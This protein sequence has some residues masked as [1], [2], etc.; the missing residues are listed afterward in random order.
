[1]SLVRAV[2]VL[3]QTQTRI[4]TRTTDSNRFPIQIWQY[5]TKTCPKPFTSTC[6]IVDDVISVFPNRFVLRSRTA[7]DD[8]FICST[9]FGLEIEIPNPGCDQTKFRYI[10]RIVKTKGVVCNIRF[11]AGIRYGS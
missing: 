7:K 2:T 8:I 11:I 9:V 10:S 3:R 4:F 6:T 5:L 1:M